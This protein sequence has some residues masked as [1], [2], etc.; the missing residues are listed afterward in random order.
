ML[1]LS[2]PT[3]IASKKFLATFRTTVDLPLLAMPLKKGMTCHESRSPR[4][5]ISRPS[6]MYIQS[7]TSRGNCW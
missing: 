7:H 3:S 6:K 1:L 5:Y 2:T 4:S